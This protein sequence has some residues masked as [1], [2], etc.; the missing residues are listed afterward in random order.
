MSNSGGFFCDESRRQVEGNA[1]EADE[2]EHDEHH[3]VGGVAV[4]HGVVEAV[5]KWH[6]I[7]KEPLQRSK[8][9]VVQI[10]DPSRVRI[11]SAIWTMSISLKSKDFTIVLSISREIHGQLSFNSSALWS[12]V[13]GSAS[14]RACASRLATYNH[15]QTM[16]WWLWILSCLTLMMAAI[17]AGT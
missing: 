15:L 4:L 10:S 1:F 5:S 6:V 16:T 8:Q 9:A 14:M 12:Q 17:S 7:C 11:A 2:A 3:V 13:A